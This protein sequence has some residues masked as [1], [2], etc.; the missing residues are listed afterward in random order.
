MNTAPQTALAEDPD[1]M[2][3]ALRGMLERGAYAEAA[4]GAAA[5]VARFPDHRDLLYCLAVAER[6][7]QDIPGA[8]HTLQTLEAYY[9]RFSRLYQE[10]G[11]CHIFRR[12]ATEAIR[13]FER[14]IQLNPALPA[15]WKSLQSLYAL[16]GRSQ[17][18]TTAGLHV[19]KLASLPGAV[20]TA[21]AMVADGDLREAEDLIRPHLAQHPRDV[22]A[23]R[24]LANIARLNEVA[25]DAGVLLEAV[26]QLAP[27]YHAA[28]Y[29]YVLALI[30]L[31]KHR[32]AL[33]QV[34]RLIAADS[35]N[36]ANRI[37]R[38]GILVSLG[39]LD[40]AVASY[41]ELAVKL[42]GDPELRQSLGHALKTMGKQQEAVEAY[43]DAVRVRPGFGEV[44]WS[45]AN[46]K[47]YR[48]TDEELELMR[49]EVAREA[50]QPQ[51][52]YHL[53]FA[54]GKAL[55]DRAEYES[56]FRYYE[57]GNA[58][59]KRECRYGPAVIERNA[60]LQ[61]DLCTPEFF[62][63]RHGWGAMGN[64]PIFIVGLP[65]AG[66]TLIEQILASHSQIEGTMELAD[67]PRLV[68]QLE[69]R[70]TPGGQP[71][72]PGVLAE[73]TAEDCARFGER[74]LADTL[75]YRRGKP[76]FIDKMPNNFRHLGLIHLVLPNARIIDAR[77]EPMACCFSNF[78]QLFASGQQFTYSL[79]DI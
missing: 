5:A 45:L 77:R 75:P 23:L 34:D 64:A 28:R 20:T 47:T 3:G 26:L 40:E 13:A 67:I 19:A 17:D 1:A 79:E 57:Q 73:L 58:L 31:H 9:P 27:A 2:A 53:C 63:A 70:A 15:S 72:Y 6:M 50:M 68:A 44:W 76:F 74:Y 22:E 69:G 42:P 54:L 37:T 60:R 51:D 7:R 49:R 61:R 14:A 12:D 21:R 46:L 11:H 78:K 10:R 30:D 35:A 36:V 39:R 29:D 16:V 48:F 66:S 62:A 18:A 24:L 41:R 71:R 4:T 32:E 43:R 65:R 55:E 38:A 25:I 56:S 33:E 8:L 59:K 52:R